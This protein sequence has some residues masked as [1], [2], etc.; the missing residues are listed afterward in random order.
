V[1]VPGEA[2]PRLIPRSA[3][4]LAPDRSFQLN[5]TA[6]GLVGFPTGTYTFTA[7][8]T[9]GGSSVA[10]DTLGSSTPLVAPTI[11]SHANNQIIAST[12]P[13]ISW[14]AVP[15]A[16]TY[17]VGVRNGYMDQ[18]LFSRYTTGTSLTLPSGVL[19]RGRR[20]QIFVDTFDHINGT[21]C[22]TPGCTG[23]DANA[24]ARRYTEAEIQGPDIFLTFPSSNYTAGQTLD[25]TARVWNT[26]APVTVDA[27]VWVGIP[28]TANPIEV[29]EFKNVFLPQ[30]LSGDVYNGPLGFSYTF[31]GSEPNGVYVVGFRLLD[32][33]SGETIAVTTRTFTKS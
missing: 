2:T 30:N 1:L 18:F 16:L 32:P 29:L 11:T 5:L 4:D 33:S 12:S 26:H 27:V 13:T 15:G 19:V 28:G 20:F 10:T 14:D 23:M 7:T 6:A 24:K 21:G 22:G 3:S 25:I 17:R 8:D 31:N 9:A